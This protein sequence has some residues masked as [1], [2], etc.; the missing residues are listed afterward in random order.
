MLPHPRGFRSKSNTSFEIRKVAYDINNP[1]IFNLEGTAGIL[2]VYGKLLED[3]KTNT[4]EVN[5]AIARL[6]RME[7][8]G[9]GRMRKVVFRPNASH[10]S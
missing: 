6:V 7:E 8:G 2:T 10:M 1:L 9:G 4:L 5:N 3:W